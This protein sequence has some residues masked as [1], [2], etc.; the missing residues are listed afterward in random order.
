MPVRA[1][2][3]SDPPRSKVRDTM[4]NILRLVPKG[5]SN[6]TALHAGGVVRL[7]R[8]ADGNV[9]L[10]CIR[11]RAR[12]VERAAIAISNDEARAIAAL[13]GQAA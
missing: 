10:E 2:A 5:T 9:E 6:R 4:K 3:H 8:L 13:L 11:I 7:A 12:R 1:P